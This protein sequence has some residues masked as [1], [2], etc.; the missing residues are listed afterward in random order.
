MPRCAPIVGL[1]AGLALWAGP[2][3]G[4]NA[5]SPW[6]FFSQPGLAPEQVLADFEECRDL[7]GR[8]QPPRTDPGVYA[9]DP[10]GAA[11][12]GFLEGMQRGEQRRNMANAAFRKC[13]AVKGYT[14]HELSKAEAKALYAGGWEQQFPRMVDRALQPVTGHP[15]LD[16]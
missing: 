12:V 9:P 3:A 11:T 14:R 10:V 2:A 8:V 4:G 15:R 6:F 5:V 16:P 13:L 1:A 7:A